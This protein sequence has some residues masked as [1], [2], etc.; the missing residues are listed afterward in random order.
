MK[1]LE[2]YR[3]QLQKFLAKDALKITSSQFINFIE[4]TLISRKF[5]TVRKLSSLRTKGPTVNSWC[6]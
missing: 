4:E 5:H 1:T 3:M 2:M 6:I